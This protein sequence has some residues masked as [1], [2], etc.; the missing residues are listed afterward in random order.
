MGEHRKQGKTFFVLVDAHMQMAIHRAPSGHFT[1]IS[2]QD[3]RQVTGA[4]R[5]TQAEAAAKMGL[6]L[7][8][9]LRKFTL[10]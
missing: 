6:T 10:K 5:I 7:P 8:E 4:M 1:C 9:L 3:G 2:Y